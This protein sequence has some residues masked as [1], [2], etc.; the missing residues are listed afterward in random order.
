MKRTNVSLIFNIFLAVGFILLL[1]AGFL[2]YN[3]KKFERTALKA[4]GRVVDLVENRNSSGGKSSR[5]YSPVV[6]YTDDKGVEHRYIASF[7]SNPPAYEVGET[8]VIYYDPW[9]PDNAAI[10]GWGSY[11]GAIIVGGI[12]LLFTLISLGFHAV[13]KI[14]HA[15]NARLKESGQLVLADFI[16]VDI[17]EYVSVNNRHPFFIRCEWKDPLTGEKK[18]FKSGFLWSDPT[19]RIGAGKK[20]SVYIDGDNPK[21]Y[22]VDITPYEGHA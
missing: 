8:V 20:I 5:T 19:P 13:R 22:Y 3:T 9:D 6:I 2:T 11:L 17:N 7:S 14:R 18:A 12:G 10:A 1:V 21:K 16:S 15:S 4:N